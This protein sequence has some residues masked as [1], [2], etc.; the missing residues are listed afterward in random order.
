MR[1]LLAL[2]VLVLIATIG[3]AQQC[4]L[5]TGIGAQYCPPGNPLTPGLSAGFFTVDYCVTTNELL[6][7]AYAPPPN[8][9]FFFMGPNRDSR[10][11]YNWTGRLCVGLPAYRLLGPGQI[12]N[13][14]FNGQLIIQSLNSSIFIPGDKWY[15][16]GWWR[17][18]NNGEGVFMNAYEITIP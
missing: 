14:S 10:N 9:G 2:T 15:L 12:F 17:D 13:T 1:N 4:S 6:M 3:S 16:Q 8:Y 11:P 18:L 5:I 7:W